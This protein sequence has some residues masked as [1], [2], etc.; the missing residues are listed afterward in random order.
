MSHYKGV[1]LSSRYERETELA[2]MRQIVDALSPLLLSRIKEIWCDSKAGA[3]YAVTMRA[4]PWDDSFATGIHA[5]FMTQGGHNG[6]S[7]QGAPREI[8]IEPEWE[9]DEL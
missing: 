1:D 2:E 3:C 4:G 5:A 8:F 9:G 7:I 6:I